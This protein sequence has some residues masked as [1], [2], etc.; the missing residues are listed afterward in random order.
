MMFKIKE[1]KNN[2]ILN[3]VMIFSIIIFWCINLYDIK[4]KVVKSGVVTFNYHVSFILISFLL[5]GI[6]FLLYKFSYKKIYKDIP[7]LF[8]ITSLV[9]GSLFIVLSP[10]FT[11]SDEQNHFYRIYEITEGTFI[12]PTKSTVGSKMPKSLQKLYEA[13][14]GGNTK[15]KYKDIKNMNKIKL[16]K[17]EKKVY[18]DSW[19]SYYSNTALYSPV[20]YLPQVTGVLIG[21]TLNLR[22]Y[23]LGIFG[24]IF[25]LLFYCFLGYLCLKIIPKFKLFYFLILISPNM[26][27]CAT[28]LQAD[29]FTN[30]IFLLILALL[31]NIIFRPE[32]IKRVEEI[33][34]FVL[35][36]VMSLCKIVY[37][38]IIFL[39]LTINDKK[40][41]NTKKEK[42]I[43]IALTLICSVFVSLLWMKTTGGVFELSYDKTELQKQFILSD[44]VGYGIILLRTFSSYIINYIEC[45]FVGTTMYHSQLS[46]PIIISFAYVIVVY[47]SLTKEKGKNQILK[48]SRYLTF[49]VGTIIT[50]LI[51]T[52]LYMQ[53]TAQFYSVG[54]STIEGIQGRYFIPVVFLIPPIVGPIKQKIKLN[55]SSMLKI[56]LSI[57]LITYFYMLSQFMI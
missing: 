5:S 27:Q 10:L 39:L 7:K 38:P 57:N 26:L 42:N 12:T 37:L 14:Y 11:G 47:F 40:F 17:K 45:L 35:S 50:V 4:Y 23:M 44:P 3:V 31:L 49:I 32:K 43:F 28:T 30:S 19:N 53:C 25:N 54:N 15:I 51:C 41:K 24:R 33:L 9:L 52:A 6:I 21:K 36:V 34:L 13:K 46:M 48:L 20:Q 18:G 22:P 2:N 16:N 1:I 8:I 29:A 56:S 55:E